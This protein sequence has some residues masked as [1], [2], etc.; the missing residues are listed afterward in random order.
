MEPFSR[1]TGTEELLLIVT[2]FPLILIKALDNTA[3]WSS[4]LNNGLYNRSS[5]SERGEIT[6]MKAYYGF[7]I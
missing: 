5:F 4:A 6:W 1:N 3:Y 7:Q 2:S